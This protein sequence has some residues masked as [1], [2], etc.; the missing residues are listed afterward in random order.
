MKANCLRL[1]E[2]ATYPQVPRPANRRSAGGGL[3]AMVAH[4]MGEASA[5]ARVELEEAMNEAPSSEIAGRSRRAGP[6]S[7]RLTYALYDRGAA[8]GFVVLLELDPAAERGLVRSFIALPGGRI[9]TLT[10]AV[11]LDTAALDARELRLG[12]LALRRELD[13]RQR[14]EL[15]GRFVRLADP[16]LL[17]R[18]HRLLGARD[19]LVDVTLDV[20]VAPACADVEGFAGG[21]EG[22][23]GS[24]A[25]ARRA[26]AAAEGRR[27]EGVG[28][29]EGTLRIDAQRVDLSA[30]GGTTREVGALDWREVHAWRVFR[31]SCAD[32]TLVL[33]QVDTATGG[34]YEGFIARHGDTRAVRNAE[35]SL[36][37][38]DAT[39]PESLVLGAIDASG[40]EIV[41]QGRARASLPILVPGAGGEVLYR[42]V[43]F[44]F[45]GRGGPGGGWSWFVAPHARGPVNLGTEGL[46]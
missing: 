9:L 16:D 36:S 32:A 10:D 4:P 5:A 6:R 8:H 24:S 30:F 17:L 25:L 14:L 41:A 3:R 43:L 15:S 7:A 11:W 1:R 31:V 33:H 28:R 34:A 45:H 12:G 29:F 22:P 37:L 18:P 19:D 27:S 46:Y 40:Y 13:G 39:V 23:I 20:T 42:A 35:V 26:L 44:D 38:R 21:S 2:I